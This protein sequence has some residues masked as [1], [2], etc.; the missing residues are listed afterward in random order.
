MWLAASASVVG[1][2]IYEVTEVIVRELAP[3]ERTAELTAAWDLAPPWRRVTLGGANAR[4]A[5]AGAPDEA[6]VLAFG[7]P[8][9]DRSVPV[10]RRGN[11]LV[12]DREAIHTLEL[13]V[14]ALLDLSALPASAMSADALEVAFEGRVVLRGS[15]RGEVGA[16]DGRAAWLT[17]T[18]AA[19]AWTGGEA[20][21]NGLTRDLVVNLG[22]QPIVA[23]L[24]PRRS[25]DPLR[26]DGRVRVTLTWGTGAAA[27]AESWELGWLREPAA[28][29]PVGLWSPATG[30]LVG[31][32]DALAVTVRNIAGLVTASSNP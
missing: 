29:A 25:P 21:R 30:R 20:A 17:D 28:A 22:R 19:A 2:L 3:I 6:P 11:V 18:P 9:D 14:G 7:P 16:S 5:L 1:R 15:R 32:D 13:P 24:A 4:P 31:I 27:R 10:L 8:L 23:V 12:A 26:D